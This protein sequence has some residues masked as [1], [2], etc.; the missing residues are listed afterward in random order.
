MMQKIFLLILFFTFSFNTLSQ[1]SNERKLFSLDGNDIGGYIGFNG[2][3]TT[4]N[5]LSA[6]LID[7]RIAV[8]VNKNW[9]FGFNTSG[10]LNDRHLNTLVKDDVY[11]LMGSYQGLFIERIFEINNDFRYS[12]SIMIGQGNAKYEYCRSVIADKKWYEEIIDQTDF[13]IIQPT[14]DIYYNLFDNFWFGLNAGFNLTTSIRMM[15]TDE[16][17]LNKAN[18]GLSL[19]YGLF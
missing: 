11:H 14:F 6:G 3:L 18:G 15:E 16:A 1:N 10:L 9:A 7:L 5:S 19:K 2:R 8:V 12:F 13:Y 4:V 17:L